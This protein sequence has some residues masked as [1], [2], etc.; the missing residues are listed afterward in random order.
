MCATD[1][2]SNLCAAGLPSDSKKKTCIGFHCKRPY[3]GLRDVIGACH[4]TE[5]EKRFRDTV[6]CVLQNGVGLP[7][8]VVP[9]PSMPGMYDG[10]SEIIRAT[11]AANSVN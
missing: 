10:S 5:K 8:L 3:A 1:F 7:V 2:L 6:V 4:K 9:A 11:F